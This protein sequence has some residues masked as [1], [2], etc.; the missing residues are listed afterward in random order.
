MHEDLTQL[1]LCSETFLEVTIMLVLHKQYFL[2]FM[3]CF[4]SVSLGTTA[5]A[6][7]G[8]WHWGN[9]KM[10][11]IVFFVLNPGPDMSML[12]LNDTVHEQQWSIILQL[13]SSRVARLQLAVHTVSIDQRLDSAATSWFPAPFCNYPMAGASAISINDALPH[14]VRHTHLAMCMHAISRLL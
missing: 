11:L 10:Y 12:T 9:R 3:N 1:D 7:A 14:A 2:C 5:V 13:Q 4:W 8:L 6:A